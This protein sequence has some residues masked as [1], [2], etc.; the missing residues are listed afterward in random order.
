[1][2]VNHVFK[3]LFLLLIGGC[4]NLTAT[5][6]GDQYLTRSVSDGLHRWKITNGIVQYC[7]AANCA[8]PVNQPPAVPANA[9]TILLS[10]G[11]LWL[12]TGRGDY[13]IFCGIKPDCTPPKKGLDLL[14]AG[15]EYQYQSIGDN[16]ISAIDPTDQHVIKC[17]F[18]P[19]CTP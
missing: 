17:D 12:L 15:M 6:A 5:S 8:T 4:V 9:T 14:P 11:G 13:Q 16:W 10:N 18:T 2:R 3:N 19:N 7:P 1:M